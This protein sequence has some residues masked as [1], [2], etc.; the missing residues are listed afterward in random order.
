MKDKHE[1]PLPILTCGTMG[2]QELVTLARERGLG[3]EAARAVAA[4]DGVMAR[5]RRNIMR[6]EFG[7]IMLAQVAPDLEVAHMDVIAAIG[8]RAEGDPDEVTVGLI[9]ERLGID[10]S[11]GRPVSADVVDRGFAR[12][13]ASQQDARRICLELTP[14]GQRFVDAIRQ[15]KMTLFASALGQWQESELIVFANLLDRFSNWAT[16]PNLLAE[17]AAEVRAALEEP[18]AKPRPKRQPAKVS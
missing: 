5:I 12:R 2:D 14:K 17:R 6:R 18:E 11:S 4:I 9:A 7:R 16:D 1:T 10:P 13:V 8:Y 3:E 15:N